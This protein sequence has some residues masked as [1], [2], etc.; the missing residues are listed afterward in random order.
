MNS[1]Q[2]INLDLTYPTLPSHGA[3]L[4]TNFIYSNPTWA[5]TSLYTY[6]VNNY[7]MFL[8]PSESMKDVFSDACRKYINSLPSH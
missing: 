6:C 7:T 8:A 2:Q 3:T 5:L 4:V 1:G